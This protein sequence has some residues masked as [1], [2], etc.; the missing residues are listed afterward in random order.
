MWNSGDTGVD[1]ITDFHVDT[2]GVNSDALNLSQ[3]LSGEHADATSLSHYLTFAFSST[4]TTIDV[5]AVADGPV[6]QQ[7]VLDGVDLSAVYAS[8]DTATIITGM[9]DDHALKVDA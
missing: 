6:V 8:A 9:L 4:E 3:L 2:A 1:H 7:V 5:K